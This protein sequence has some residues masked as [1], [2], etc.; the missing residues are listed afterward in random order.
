MSWGREQQAQR[1]L[2]GDL[3]GLFGDHVEAYLIGTQLMEQQ[4][5]HPFFPLPSVSPPQL[6]A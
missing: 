6:L 2:G 1:S 4:G 3:L 5:V